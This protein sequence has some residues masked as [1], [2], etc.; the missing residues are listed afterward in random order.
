MP[1]VVSREGFIHTFIRLLPDDLRQ[2]LASGGN[3]IGPN[4]GIFPG[5]ES[6]VISCSK[7]GGLSLSASKDFEFKGKW[8]ISK[9]RFYF[10]I[11][12]LKD[13]FYIFKEGDT[14]GLYDPTGTLFGKFTISGS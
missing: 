12:G 2:L 1:V 13:Y 8:W 11:L 6:L 7:E 14:L 4:N 10:N 9:D 5:G 3:W